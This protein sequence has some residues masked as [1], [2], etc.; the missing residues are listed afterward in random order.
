MR[1]LVQLSAEQKRKLS[2]A[3]EQAYSEQGAAGVDS[4]LAQL[5]AREHIHVPVSNWSDRRQLVSTAQSENMQRGMCLTAHTWVLAAHTD[6]RDAQP[7]KLLCV[8]TSLAAAYRRC[9]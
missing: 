6:L 8:M 2:L 4:L 5:A 9:M 7:H 3:I 1:S